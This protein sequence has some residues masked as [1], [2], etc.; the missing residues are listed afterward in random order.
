MIDFSDFIRLILLFVFYI[1]VDEI[2]FV[3]VKDFLEFMRLDRNF[4]GLMECDDFF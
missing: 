1:Y 4:V 2:V 3:S